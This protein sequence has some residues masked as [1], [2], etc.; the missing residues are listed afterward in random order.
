MQT[1]VDYKHTKYYHEPTYHR[2]EDSTYIVDNSI[3]I[4]NKNG[5]YLLTITPMWHTYKTRYE[6]VDGNPIDKAVAESLL[7]TRKKSDNPPSKITPNANNVI[8]IH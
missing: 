2:N 6:D 1:G 3:K 5:N 4:N 7:P 8:F